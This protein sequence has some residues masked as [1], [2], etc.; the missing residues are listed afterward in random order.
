MKTL[1]FVC[2]VLIAILS[3]ALIVGSNPSFYVQYSRHIEEKKALRVYLFNLIA[4]KGLQYFQE[5]TEGQ[6]CKAS[7]DYSNSTLIVNFYLFPPACIKV[8]ESAEC[9]SLNFQLVNRS[10]YTSACRELG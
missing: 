1:D 3:V 7:K 8:K 5:A 6:L 10:V 4:E 9:V 2:A